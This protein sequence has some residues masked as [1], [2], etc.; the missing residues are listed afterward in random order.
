MM[1]FFY[2]LTPFILSM[3][4]NKVKQ[5]FVPIAIIL[6]VML[7]QISV[8]IDCCF[9]LYFPFYVMGLLLSKKIISDIYRYRYPCVVC[10]FF[11]F[12]FFTWL[13]YGMAD[14]YLGGGRFLAML[15]GLVFLFS[16]SPAINKSEMATKALYYVSYSSMTAYLFHRQIYLSLALLLGDSNKELNLFTAAC[17]A[18]PCVFVISYMLQK[19]YD[20]LI[21]VYE[22]YQKR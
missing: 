12:F 9:F 15:S 13:T 20:K 17:F 4:R 19:T 8:E 11:L 3:K 1:M 16:L 18:V 2:S 21:S 10:S 7:V 5:I 14:F 22:S 6:A